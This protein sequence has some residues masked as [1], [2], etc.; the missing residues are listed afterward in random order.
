MGFTIEI[1]VYA[2]FWTGLQL[3]QWSISGLHLILIEA[4]SSFLKIKITKTI[5]L[6]FSYCVHCHSFVYQQRLIALPYHAKRWVDH[7]RHL[8]Q[9]SWRQWTYSCVSRQQCCKFA[10]LWTPFL[11]AQLHEFIRSFKIYF[12]KKRVYFHLGEWKR[13]VGNNYL[14]AWELSMYENTHVFSFINIEI[15]WICL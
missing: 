3:D 14:T 11:L 8:L 1:N 7:S 4:R 9:F 6:A 12:I 15:I 13:Q 10:W 5:L 2:Y